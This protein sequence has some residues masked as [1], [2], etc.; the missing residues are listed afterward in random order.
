MR[1]QGALSLEELNEF[2]K[3]SQQSINENKRIFMAR[4]RRR[5]DGEVTFSWIAARLLLFTIV[6]GL[7]LGITFLKRNNLKRGDELRELDAKLKIAREEAESLRSRLVLCK[8]PR[9]LESRM[10]ALGI[11]MVRPQE[12]QIRRLRDPSDSVDETGRRRMLAFAGST[13]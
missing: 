7:V 5:V 11:N 8:A 10:A 1:E 2:H 6:V 9:A 3:N 12:S 13:R 4:N